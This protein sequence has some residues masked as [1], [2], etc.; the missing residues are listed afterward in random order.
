MELFKKKI[1]KCGDGLTQII[2][3]PTRKSNTP[4][5]DKVDDTVKL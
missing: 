4:A 3:N 2:N 5:K 1:I